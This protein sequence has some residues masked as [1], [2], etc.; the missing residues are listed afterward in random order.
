[1]NLLQGKV[2]IVTG[3]GGGLGE[4]YALALAGAGARVVV[5][6]P[7][8]GRDGI[9]GTITMADTVVK[10]IRDVG[11]EAAANYD[12]VATMGGA[13]AIFSTAMDAYGQVDI[14]VNNAGILRDAAFH[15]MTEEEW[16]AVIAVHLKGTFCIT[17]LVFPHMRERGSGVVIGISSPTGLTG[18][19]GQANY[20]AAKGGVWGLMNCLAREGYRRGEVDPFARVFTVVPVAFT[21]MTAD[22]P[23][24]S[25]EEAKAQTDPKFVA[26]LVVYLASDLSAGMTDKTFSVMGSRI[27]EMR[28]VSSHGATKEDD[29]G[30]WSA[31]EISRRMSEI[32]LADKEAASAG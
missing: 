4:Q 10:K 18:N 28:M 19:F 25:S 7:G 23:Q 15:N 12:S 9:G 3:S 16:D 32:L 17:R 31:Q 6:D 24:F 14:L 26:P 30:L 13:E 5:N 29:G 27:R 1:M 2:A 22:L 21:R 20:G 8:S 11:G